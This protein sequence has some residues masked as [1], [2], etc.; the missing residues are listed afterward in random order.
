MNIVAELRSR[1]AVA[2]RSIDEGS[3][4]FAQMVLPAQDSKFGDYQANCA[5]PLG[6]RLK[7]PPR[8]IASALV[9]AL[10]VDDLCD[11]PEIAGPGFINLRLC[12]DWIAARLQ[13]AW[14]SGDGLG[15]ERVEAPR[16]FIID[17]SSPNVAKP[18]HVGH[19]RST[20]IGDALM[21]VLKCLGHQVITD[22]HIGDWGTQFGMILYGYKHF[23]DKHALADAPIDELSRL[24]RLVNRLVEYHA[25]RQETLPG[26]REKLKSL[27]TEIGNLKVAVRRQAVQQGSCRC[28]EAATFECSTC[29]SPVRYRSRRG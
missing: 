19:I 22:N 23:V 15:L 13:T 3:A 24:Y 2:L 28:Q 1:F 26:L 29:A 16:T 11:P 4:E 7:K 21:R 27:T 12:D 20:V 14:A 17:Y 25:A 18:M 9:D 5:M 6:K 8:E 10:D